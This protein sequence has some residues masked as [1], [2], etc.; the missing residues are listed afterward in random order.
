VQRP[1]PVTLSREMIRYRPW[2]LLSRLYPHY[3]CAIPTDSVR[4]QSVVLVKVPHPE[5]FVPLSLVLPRMAVV[6]NSES[7]RTS[8]VP[9][10]RS[11][12]VPGKS[13]IASARDGLT[14]ED[15]RCTLSRYLNHLATLNFERTNHQVPGPRCPV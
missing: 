4:P 5:R 7:S 9:V 3:S 12:F 13:V 2:P 15:Q 11:S 10:K 8:S 1:Y 6:P 14:G